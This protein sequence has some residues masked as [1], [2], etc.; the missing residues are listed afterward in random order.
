MAESSG[1]SHYWGI[2]ALN[3]K[4]VLIA[5]AQHMFH[6]VQAPLSSQPAILTLLHWSSSTEV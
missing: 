1:T 4:A 6:M 5:M 3:Q 2:I